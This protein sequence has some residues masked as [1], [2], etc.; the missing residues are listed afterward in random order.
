MQKRCLK[1][2][3]PL[4]YIFQFLHK[5]PTG[6]AIMEWPIENPSSLHWPILLLFYA[7]FL[8]I[9]MCNNPNIQIILFSYI[10]VIN[11]TVYHSTCVVVL[12]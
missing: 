10:L 8:I 1:F 3:S 9:Y 12:I 5:S 7:L 11:K 6:N 4:L 2:L